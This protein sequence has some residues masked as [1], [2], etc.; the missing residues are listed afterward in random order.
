MFQSHDLVLLRPGSYSKRWRKTFRVHDEG[1]V[2]ANPYLFWQSPEKRRGKEA[3]FPP[4]PVTG[5]VG[6]DYFPSF[7]VGNAL[8]AKDTPPR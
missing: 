4:F 1:M 5:L 3:N 6:L 7:N 2:P 8:V